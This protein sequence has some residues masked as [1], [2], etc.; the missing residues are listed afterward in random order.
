MVAQTLR[1]PHNLYRRYQGNL[2]SIV[3][4]FGLAL[5]VTFTLH[6][7]LIYPDNWVWVIGTATALIG[8]RWPSIAF[9]I[10]VIAITYPLTLINIYLGVLF[11][12]VAVLGHRLF[13]H[14]LG[15]TVLVLATPLLA[16]FHL[17]WLVPIMIGLW[18]GN[19]TVAWVGGLAALWGKIVA[20]IAGY[21]I[22]WL[23]IAGK[24]IQVQDIT[25]RFTEANS[26]E[27]LLLIVEPFAA[28]SNVVLYNLLQILGWAIA[29]GF[30]GSLAGRKWVK[31]HA[32][33][34]VLVISAAGGLIMLT[35]HL[36]LPYWLHGAVST[37]ALAVVENPLGPL[38]SLIVV[39]I[40]GTVI[41][42]VRERLD[43]PVAPR[44]LTTYRKQK[45]KKS[46][47]LNL[48]KRS[49]SKSAPPTETA[50]PSQPTRQPVRVPDRSEL[51]EW[52][53]P[54]ND[55]GLI[56]LEID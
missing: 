39:I 9:S 46:V 23:V 33:W 32:P 40:V 42:S 51:P 22:D 36:L 45:P 6:S 50:E 21:N 41:Y 12:A 13:V 30:V 14:Y 56:M 17:H 53:P 38:F 55:S 26:L 18:W 29:A 7:L 19:V 37:E 1:G 47:S 15:A 4:A 43:L 3:V 5:V 20:G 10:A 8:I 2:E 24:T 52:T 48:F 44:K 31:Y 35:T 25:T 34:S 27:T 11:L 16:E 28:D 54:V 49:S